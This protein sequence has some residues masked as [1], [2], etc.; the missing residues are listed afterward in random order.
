MTI[1]FSHDKKSDGFSTVK[2]VG[3]ISDQDLLEKW[4]NH[5][6]SNFWI[7]GAKILGDLSKA[8]LSAV[9]SE[10]IQQLVSMFESFIAKHGQNF[11]STKTALFAPEA[12]MFGMSKIFDGYGV[13]TVGEIRVF[14][15]IEK[16]KS[17][18]KG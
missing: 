17:W 5:L 12:F 4:R 6:E 11:K 13:D 18:L 3:K 16:A 10:G 8:D 15:D 2:Y 7:P 1:I 14:S 9:T